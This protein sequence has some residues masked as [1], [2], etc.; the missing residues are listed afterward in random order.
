MTNN[1]REITLAIIFMTGLLVALVVCIALI[2][3]R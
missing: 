2:R 3:G 1:Q